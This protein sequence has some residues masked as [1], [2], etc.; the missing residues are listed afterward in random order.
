MTGYLHIVELSTHKKITFICNKELTF[1]ELKEW[2]EIKDWWDFSNI[3]SLYVVDLG[4][5]K[6]IEIRY[7]HDLP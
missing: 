2:V 7:E 3:K 4:N 5:T 6:H 1:G